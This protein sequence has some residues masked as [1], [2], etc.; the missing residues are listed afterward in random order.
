MRRFRPLP[1]AARAAA[2][3]VSVAL[4][5]AAAE[6]ARGEDSIEY[7]VA[8]ADAVVVA[9][10]ADL[11]MDPP[12]AAPPRVRATLAVSEVIK[13]PAPQRLPLIVPSFHF[14]QFVE[15]HRRG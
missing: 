9:S 12:G 10:V 7:M 2:A 3:V 1:P 11:K 8:D 5:L 15:W 6:R 14:Q 13:G 4:L